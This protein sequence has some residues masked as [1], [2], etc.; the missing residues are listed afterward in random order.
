MAGFQQDKFQRVAQRIG[1]QSRL[2]RA[3]DLPGGISAG[4]TALELQLPDGGTKK[5]ILR[6]PNPRA[7]ARNP[8]AAA[9]EFR[10]LRVLRAAGV[11]APEPCLLDTSAEILATPYLVLE[12]VEGDLEFGPPDLEDY[13]C[14]L[15]RHLAG[16]HRLD[17]TRFDLA[18]L[19]RQAGWC[20]EIPPPAPGDADDSLQGRR[21]QQVLEATR[22]LP[23]PNRPVLLHG[24]YWP[25]NILWRDGRLVAVVD[26]EDAQLGDPLVD[27]GKSR[28]EVAWIFGMEA[29]RT[30][31]R[32]YRSRMDLDY[33]HLPYWDLCAALRLMRLAGPNL[34]EW[35]A[36]FAPFGR[37]DITEQTM[38]ADYRAFVDQAFEDLVAA[39]A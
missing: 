4:M 33:G 18:F 16:I 31:T 10:L 3:W 11:A 37:P 34:G 32:H 5:V 35:A 20:T 30:F 26:W 8:E 21:I 28:L 39:V 38:R 25:G 2:L 22:P 13:L 15:A 24:D 12:Y 9:G 1:P 14:Q 6:R 36:F 27:L 23:Q 7:L 17:G 29:M 19:P